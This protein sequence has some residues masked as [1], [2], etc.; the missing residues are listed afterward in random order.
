MI[1]MYYHLEVAPGRT[2]EAEKLL[3][4]WASRMKGNPG[5]LGCYVF[6][7]V[8]HHGGGDYGLMHDWQKSE[9]MHNF[10]QKNQQFVP[11]GAAGTF[12]PDEHGHEHDEHEGPQKELFHRE[13][14]GHYE[15][16]FHV[17]P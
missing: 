4:E 5:F 14:H 1:R 13:F 6:K 3:K 7:E 10:W 2:D 15:L 16:I 12:H 17:A 9:D 8:G 11:P